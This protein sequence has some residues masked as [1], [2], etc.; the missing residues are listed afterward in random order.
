MTRAL[1]NLTR[2]GTAEFAVR[3]FIDLGHIAVTV[4]AGRQWR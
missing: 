4:D 3:I 1:I 2:A